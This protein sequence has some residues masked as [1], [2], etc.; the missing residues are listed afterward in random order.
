MGDLLQG[1][2]E[3]EEISKQFQKIK[4]LVDRKLVTILN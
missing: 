3:N 4:Q 2:P 1:S